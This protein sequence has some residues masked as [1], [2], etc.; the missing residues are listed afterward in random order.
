MKTLSFDPIRADV[1][2]TEKEKSAAL[3]ANALLHNGQGAG[4]DFLGWVGLPSALDE[5]ELQA[6]ETEAARLRDLAEVILCIGIGGSYLGARAV[7]EALSDR[8]TC[9]MNIRRTP[10]CFSSDRTCRKTIW[11][12]CSQPSRTG[13]SR[14]S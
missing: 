14:P 12:V 7:Y 5:E 3:H 1:A 10:F 11:P 9:C 2:I 6:I 4:N 13:R 8:S